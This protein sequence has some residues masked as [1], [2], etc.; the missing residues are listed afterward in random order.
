MILYCSEMYIT[1][2]FEYTEHN[3]KTNGLQKS[4]ANQLNMVNFKKD[5]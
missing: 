4:K 2:L 1:S 5:R 3:K